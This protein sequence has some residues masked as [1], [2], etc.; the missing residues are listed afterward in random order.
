MDYYKGRL[1]LSDEV[2]NQI[3]E[4]ITSGEWK[5]GD[6]LPSES[7]LCSMF[8]VSRTSVRAALQNLQGSGIVVTMQGV[9]SFVHRN[10][11]QG[12]TNEEPPE[13]LKSSDISSEEF[14]EFFEFRQAIEFKAIE[15]FVRR[16]TKENEDVLKDLVEKM[17][18]AAKIDDRASF[19]QY[20]LDFHMAIIE[21]AKN[22]FLYNSMLNYKDIFS[23]Y[24]EE[25]TRLTDKPLTVLAEEHVELYT[26][27]I[28]K[29]PKWAKDYLFC[30]N[31]YYHVAYF[32]GR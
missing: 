14:K 29:K 17:Q 7:K 4:Q 21:G 12:V 6:K 24:M 15:F 5:V 8:G 23:H 32:N 25:I 28:E 31:T 16:A 1:S 27:L 30:D 18:E 19:T 2:Y 9:G 11:E 3:L 26:Y 22:V 10:P 13:A 20:D